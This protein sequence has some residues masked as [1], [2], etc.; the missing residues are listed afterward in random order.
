MR[1]ILLYCSLFLVSVFSIFT[2]ELFAS[3]NETP[4]GPGTNNMSCSRTV[5]TRLENG[6]IACYG[7]WDY[8]REYWEDQNMCPTYDGEWYS[9]AKT[10]CKITTSI[11]K[12]GFAKATKII[13]PKSL[14]TAELTR[15][16]QLIGWT[17]DVLKWQVLK[18]WEYTCYDGI[19]EVVSEQKSNAIV[20]WVYEWIWAKS[21]ANNH[22]DQTVYLEIPST[23]EGKY[24]VLTAYEPVIWTLRN[25]KWVTPKKIIIVWYH[26]PKITT[27]DNSTLPSFEI[28][29]YETN[30]NYAYANKV[31]DEWYDRLVSWLE[32]K[33]ISFNPSDFTGTYSAAD[34]NIFQKPTWTIVQGKV[35]SE[36]MYEQSNSAKQTK[37]NTTYLKVQLTSSNSPNE[38]PISSLSEATSL[39]TDLRNKYTDK[40]AWCIWNYRV[41]YSRD[42][43]TT[44][45]ST[46][47]TTKVSRS[48]TSDIDAN[49]KKLVD[50]IVVLTK[51]RTSRMTKEA[52]IKYLDGYITR[53]QLSTP[54]TAKGK[55]SQWYLIEMLNELKK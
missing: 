18:L 35:Y 22:P 38:F 52:K 23:A 1:K 45:T 9:N 37:T 12:S 42:S 33:W 27:S 7:L 14:D 15:L 13:V 32:Q 41:I 44:M 29:S 8:G 17:S 49:S 43:D 24:L 30:R 5:S 3:T 47:M 34:L 51:S 50:R 26:A 48:T 40:V 55:A 53:L 19:T 28:N 25:P 46:W 16:A 20:Y 2:L 36:P 11:C 39:C 54:K 6:N 10:G 4:P 21:S 31:G